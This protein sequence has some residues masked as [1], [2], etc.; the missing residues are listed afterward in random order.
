[1]GIRRRARPSIRGNVDQWSPRLVGWAYN[2]ESPDVPLQLSVFVDDVEFTRLIASDA[3]N[4]VVRA[5]HEALN[6]GFS[7]EIGV[8]LDDARSIRILEVSSKKELFATPS[9]FCFRSSTLR[10]QSSEVG[11]GSIKAEFGNKDSL[12]HSVRASG[13]VAFVSSYRNALDSDGSIRWLVASLQAQGI[14]VVV[15]DTSELQPTDS[16]GAQALLWRKNVGFDFASWSTA[17]ETYGDVVASS[18]CLYLLNDSC[19]GPVNG[20]GELLAKGKSLGADV[21]SCTDSWNHGY[22]LQ[23]YFLAFDMNTDARGA[24]ERFFTSYSNP[25]AK[26]DVIVEGEL[27]LSRQLLAEG[28]SLAAAYPYSSLVE[29]FVAS[30]ELNI[31][32]K[33]NDPGVRALREVNQT[34]LPQDVVAMTAVFDAIRAGHPVNP[35]HAFWRQLLDDGFP[36]VK[37]DLLLRDPFGMSDHEEI[38]ATLSKLCAQDHLE[39]VQEDL[40]RRDGNRVQYL[41]V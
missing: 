10:A 14:A 2:P 28:L 29:R 21:W 30:F 15:I 9:D 32:R 3:R 39:V 37:R 4:D 16:F 1:M 25:L 11:I 23:S 20:F 38:F 31:A 26:S 22:H 12:T 24:V 36:L 13:S 33:M 41:E 27:A 34:Y 7:F 35:T 5:G 40:K 19:V 17:F 6:C 18:E 8:E